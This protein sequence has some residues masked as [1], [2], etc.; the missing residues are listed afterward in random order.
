MGLFDLS[1]SAVFPKK[2]E[3]EVV[4]LIIKNLLS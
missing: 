4:S 3:S 1:G 2:T